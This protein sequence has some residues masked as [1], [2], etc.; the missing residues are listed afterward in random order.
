MGIP[1][2]GSQ[3]TLSWIALPAFTLAF[4]LLALLKAKWREP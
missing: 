3:Q 4:L 2:T 1:T